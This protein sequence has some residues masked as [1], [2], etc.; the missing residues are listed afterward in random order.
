LRRNKSVSSA[1][2]SIAAAGYAACAALTVALAIA[3]A[4]IF[5]GCATVPPALDRDPFA[6]L[7]G[8]A[9]LYVALP[10]A[11]NRELAS[12]FA[13]SAASGKGSSAVIDRTR[14]AYVAIDA[15]GSMHMMAQ[16]S[17]PGYASSLLFPSSKGWKKLTVSGSSWYR[18][19]SVDVAV[20]QSGIALLAVNSDITGMV[21][22]LTHPSGG[23]LPAAAPDRSFRDQ[24]AADFAAGSGAINLFIADATPWTAVF[25]G[26]DISLPVDHAVIRALP[27]RAG[28]HSAARSPDNYIL[29]I[30]VSAPDAR[31]AKAMAS[32]VRL[33]F[34]DFDP[35]V[36]GNDIAISGISV[37]AEKLVEFAKNLYF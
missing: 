26:D 19:D 21:S 2:G 33:A 5:S 24:A 31:T 13:D 12:L 29:S 28:S 10:V 17:Y 23:S 36:S 7:G 37:N 4:V 6:I 34:P 20:P 9:A 32:L 30:V 8:G 1:A 18:R 27:Q 16:G 14:R 11:E 15:D 22:A 3:A 35:T 25:L